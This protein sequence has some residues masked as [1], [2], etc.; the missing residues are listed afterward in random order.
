MF[1]PVISQTK[2]IFRAI[3]K[4]N[5]PRVKR[6]LQENPQLANLS[7][8][9][10][11][12]SVKTP[13]TTTACQYKD[14]NFEGERKKQKTINLQIIK[15][16]LDNKANPN[17]KVNKS[18]LLFKLATNDYNIPIV[19]LLIQYG[20]DVNYTDNKIKY[21]E[22]IFSEN[23]NN[24]ALQQAV[25]HKALQMTKLLLHHGACPNIKNQ[26]KS[27]ALHNIF[28]QLSLNAIE[29]NLLE[30]LLQFGAHTNQANSEGKTPL[31]LSLF[32]LNSHIAD[33]GKYTNQQNYIENIQK[34]IQCTETLLKKGA[35]VNHII[36]DNINTL[37]RGAK[38][39][40]PIDMILHNYSEL[41]TNIHFAGPQLDN[42]NQAQLRQQLLGLLIKNGARIDH[43]EQ[44]YLNSLTTIHPQETIT[45]IKKY[46]NKRNLMGQYIRLLAEYMLQE[47]PIDVSEIIQNIT[48]LI[49]DPFVPAYDKLQ[50]LSYLAFIHRYDNIFCFSGEALRALLKQIPF[51]HDFFNDD[52]CII[53]RNMAFGLKGSVIDINAT[54]IEEAIC[55]F[56]EYISVLVTRKRNLF[57]APRW[58]GGDDISK[59]VSP[60][61]KKLLFDHFALEES[62]KKSI[63][64][65]KEDL[66]DPLVK[67]LHEKING[68]I[69]KETNTFRNRFINYITSASLMLFAP[70]KPDDS[71][72]PEVPHMPD[73]LLFKIFSY[74]KED[75][76]DK[77]YLPPKPFMPK[78]YASN[79]K[80]GKKRKRTK[81]PN[82]FEKSLKRRK[83]KI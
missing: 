28:S 5:Y 8:K 80:V 7:I 59:K 39:Y 65:C 81:E 32:Q 10:A 68:P 30:L 22:N 63:R 9:Y 74:K 54:T 61:T 48:Y 76:G 25:Q 24:T 83:K 46:I 35:Q 20:A 27:M 1:L 56:P 13:L 78:F 73:D 44:V 34:I 2:G 51:N 12:W 55:N 43:I 67:T 36:K 77:T 69:N 60:L 45:F 57:F 16:L 52:A 47:Q 3:R 26:E 79:K 31:Y 40:F 53:L 71:T 66:T 4:N 38:E 17:Q 6:L 23:Y 18:T 70:Q 58:Y 41:L 50:A 29:G 49:D 19:K 37:E 11:D 75:I 64:L 42:K 33:L 82:K 14:Q 62:A 21:P 15:L 72:L